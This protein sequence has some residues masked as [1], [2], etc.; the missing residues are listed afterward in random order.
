M[1]PYFEDEH[2]YLIFETTKSKLKLS[3]LEDL[4]ANKMLVKFVKRHSEGVNVKQSGKG[5]E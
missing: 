2:F 4:H 3:Q 1:L 5:F